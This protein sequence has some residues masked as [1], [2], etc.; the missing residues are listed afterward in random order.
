MDNRWK[1]ILNTEHH[2]PEEKELIAYLKR[3][4]SEEEAHAIEEKLLNDEFDIDALEG[5]E[6]LESP[7]DLSQDLKA[8][9]SR[10]ITSAGVNKFPRRSAQYIQDLKWGIIAIFVILLIIIIA[11]LVI[12]LYLS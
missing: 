1:K 9:K 8:L 10:I 11:I 4:V 5:L 12:Q 7:E 2:T 3:Q 6:Q